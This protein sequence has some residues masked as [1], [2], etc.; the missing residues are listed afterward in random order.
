MQLSRFL[1]DK[2]VSLAF[3]LITLLSIALVLYVFGLS[4]LQIVFVDSM[5]LAACICAT[6]LDYLRRRRF[7]SELADTIECLDKH[8]LISE[9]LERPDFVEGTLCFDA[10]AHAGKDMNDTIASY[11]IASE[12]YREYI[13]TWIH[14]IKTPLAA[15]HLIVENNR[16]RTSEALD[17]E[18]DR[19]EACVEQALY[20]S[21]AATLE[22]DYTIRANNLESMVKASLRKHSR[23]LIES[24]ITPQLEGLDFDVYTDAKWLDFI[25]GQVIANAV[26][27]RTT[28]AEHEAVLR[29]TKE[30]HEGTCIALKIEDNGIGIPK[31]DVSRVFDKGF[32]GVNGRSY[33]KSTGI[34]LY[35]CKKLC[36]KMGL[37]IDLSSVQGEGTTVTI[38][39]PLDTR[40]FVE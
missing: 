7:Y 20:Y 38:V 16:N 22:K 9:L 10:L 37:S 14:E 2:A 18:I 39:F 36:N 40:D 21:R 24:H 29:F 1:K 13:E 6:I 19:I 25:L 17:V 3:C 35:L 31:E 27:Y 12:E 26:K 30:S 11:R 28:N 15:A 4:V 32:T 8:Y 34:G 33:P 5:L 23:A